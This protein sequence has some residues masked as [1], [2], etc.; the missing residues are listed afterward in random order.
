MDRLAAMQAFAKVVETGSFTKAAEALGI[1]R[2]MATVHV[3]RL[4]EHLHVRLLNRTTRRLSLTEAGNAYYERCAAL[5]AEIDV[6]ESSLEAM[7]EEPAGVLKISAP[8]SFGVLHLGA[9]LAEFAQKHPAVRF[10]V[11]LND[12]TVD[13][14]DEGYDLAIRIA[15]LVDSSLVARRLALTSLRV[16]AAPEYVR[17]HGAPK[18]PRELAS[19]PAFGYAYSGA[20]DKW[21]FTRAGET[22]EVRVRTE[23][24]AN[25]GD[26]IRMMAMHGHGIA[27]L[28]DFIVAGDLK[29]KRLVPL[30]PGWDAPELGIFAVYPSRKYLSAKVRTLV[31]FLAARFARRQWTA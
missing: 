5:L 18:H 10:D 31:D 21:T 6:V 11:S 2:T 9:A 20:G 16:C 13:L 8:V 29:S 3:G 23:S 19:R 22:V 15:R 28:P 17:K 14:V 24:R 27:L 7:A 1:S 4:E 30:L 12:R 26:L 25:N